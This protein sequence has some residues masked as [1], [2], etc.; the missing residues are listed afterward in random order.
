M[1]Q[2]QRANALCL[3][4][5][6]DG[7]AVERV[8]EAISIALNNCLDKATK[9]TAKRK[10]VLVLTMEPDEERDMIYTFVE[11]NL[12]L[13]FEVP[14]AGKAF[15]QTDATTGEMYAVA[16]ARKGGEEQDAPGQQT[17]PGVPTEPPAREARVVQMPKAVN[18]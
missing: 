16:I 4:N 14:G 5:I 18:E 7:T 10:V 6:G 17:L 1:D 2:K 3:A 13:P 12:K 8:N 11:V 9:A 15:V